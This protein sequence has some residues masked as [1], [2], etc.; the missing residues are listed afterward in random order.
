MAKNIEEDLLDVKC[1]VHIDSN[2]Q[3]VRYTR[4]S[5]VHTMKIQ[6]ITKPT[7]YNQVLVY[8]NHQKEEKSSRPQHTINPFNL[9]KKRGEYDT[10][11]DMHD[12]GSTRKEGQRSMDSR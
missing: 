3:R 4:A 8:H 2:Q 5:Q 11:L 7:D 9:N 10:A 12:Y 1:M 6:P